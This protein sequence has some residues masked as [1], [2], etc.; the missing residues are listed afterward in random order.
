MDLKRR[1]KILSNEEAAEV[2]KH[3]AKW[4]SEIIKKR[5]ESATYAS[6]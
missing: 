5:K 2:H 4:L 1:L 6:F 3:P